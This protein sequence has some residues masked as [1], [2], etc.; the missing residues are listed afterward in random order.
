MTTTT[1]FSVVILDKNLRIMIINT[2]YEY[3]YIYIYIYERKKKEN[4]NM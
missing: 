3:I 2:A 4:G 1:N